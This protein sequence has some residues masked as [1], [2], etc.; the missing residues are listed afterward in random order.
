MLSFAAHISAAR[1]RLRV[2]S[3][4]GSRTGAG[5]PI[6]PPCATA[7]PGGA[8]AAISSIRGGRAERRSRGPAEQPRDRL[9]DQ[10]RRRIAFPIGEDLAGLGERHRVDHR[11][12]I[13]AAGGEG[14]VDGGELLAGAAPGFAAGL[15]TGCAS[16]IICAPG[17][18]FSGRRS[19]AVRRTAATASLSCSM[20]A[21]RS[22][23]F[24]AVNS[25]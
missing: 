5:M 1:A 3:A 22:R 15:A 25:G 14:A 4:S 17:R 8:D 23:T 13:A 11:V 7:S 10:M 6:A 24:S 12:G 19:P 9:H 21:S 16:P 18:P 2:R 20:L